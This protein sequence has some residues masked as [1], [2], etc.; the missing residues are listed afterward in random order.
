MSGHDDQNCMTMNRVWKS[1]DKDAPAQK[2]QQSS[3][4][5][6]EQPSTVSED[7]LEPKVTSSTTPF[8]QFIALVGHSSPVQVNGDSSSSTSNQK[9]TET[10]VLSV[11]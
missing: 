6:N 2:S 9:E 8:L 3:S 5:P 10:P 11:P 4:A 1:V 7:P